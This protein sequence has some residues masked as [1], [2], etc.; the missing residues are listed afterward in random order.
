M[1]NDSVAPIREHKRIYVTVPVTVSCPSDGDGLR[2]ARTRQ[3]GMGGC[4][5]SG[6]E[7]LREGRVVLLELDLHGNHV[8]AVAQV[9]YEYL[10]RDGTVQTGMKFVEM[11]PADS[12]RL[13][14]FIAAG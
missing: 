5:I 4:M 13:D 9:L 12:V 6:S 8:R 1:D 11:E 7:H 10:D 14:R 3:L 2:S